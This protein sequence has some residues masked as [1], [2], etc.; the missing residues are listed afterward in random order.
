V[1]LNNISKHN[2]VFSGPKFTIFYLTAIDHRLNGNSS[3]VLTATSLFYEKAKNSIPHRIKTPDRIGIKFGV[4]DNVGEG[5]RHNFMQ[6]PPRGASRKWVNYTQKFSFIYAFLFS[7]A[8]TG[9]IF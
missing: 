4:V 2:F 6:I 1:L 3:P 7:N 5:T 9:H 8:P